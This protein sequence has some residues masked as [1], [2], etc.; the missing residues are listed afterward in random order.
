MSKTHSR[1]WLVWFGCSA[2]LFYKYILQVYPGIISVNL[3]ATFHLT[4]AGMG[5]LAAAFYYSYLIAQLF[6]GVLLDK[7]N[8]RTLLSFALILCGASLILFA[9]VPVLSVVFVARML[10]GVGVAFATVGYFKMTSL[11][12]PAKQFA[13]VGSLLATAAMLGAVFGQ[14]PLAYYIG[15]VGWHQALFAVGV[16]GIVLAGYF[17]VVSQ[18]KHNHLYSSREVS[19]SFNWRDVL[20]V[21]KNKQNWYIACYGGFVFSPLAVFGG[22]WGNQ[23]LIEAYQVKATS[24]ANLLSLMF[25]GLAVG[26]PSISL[27]AT[28]LNHKKMLMLIC[29]AVGAIS[30]AMVVY[31]PYLNVSLVGGLLFLFGFASGAFM[32]GFALAQE[33]NALAVTAT[34]VAFINTGEAIFSAISDP[35]VGHLLDQGWTGAMIN[36][37][38]HFSLSNYHHALLILV[39]YVAVAFFFMCLVR[40]K[41]EP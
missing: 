35:L 32:L 11:W 22:L 37:A 15:Q 13:F 25:L 21:L 17:Y 8:P 14:G 19:A 24:A 2:F 6:A 3:M 26:A 40:T 10:M 29:A 1:A 33:L 4:G 38:R 23:F 27:V 39:I 41:H 30:L 7:Y 28:V 5:N 31:C 34:A 18:P 36:G 9:S 12:F 20:A 16:L